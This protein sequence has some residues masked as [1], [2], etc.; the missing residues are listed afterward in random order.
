MFHV[1]L[2]SAG[3]PARRPARWTAASTMIHAAIVTAAVALTM[4]ADVIPVEPP[5]APVNP[6]YLPEPAPPANRVHGDGGASPPTM[7]RPDVVIDLP[8]VPTIDPSIPFSRHTLPAGDVFARQ[9]GIGPAGPATGRPGTGVHAAGA[10]DRMVVP[11]PENPAPGYPRAL[12]SAAL[13]GAVVVVF[14]VD[15]S[16]R[17]EDGSV[18]VLEATHPQ[19]ADAVRRWLPRT[20]YVPAEIRGTR[21]RQLVQQRVEFTLRAGHGPR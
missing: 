7:P 18:R 16:G 12:R 3:A 13:E 19:F 6:V 8:A 21:V 14:V 4:R 10:V 1:L 15:S 9:P 17:V 5:A 2:E 20:R 11:S